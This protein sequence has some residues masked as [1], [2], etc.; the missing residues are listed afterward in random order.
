M[1]PEGPFVRRQRSLSRELQIQDLPAEG[2]VE[3]AAAPVRGAASADRPHW[4]TPDEAE[5]WSSLSDP[6]RRMTWAIGRGLIKVITARYLARNRTSEAMPVDPKEIQ[7]DSVDGLQRRVAPR[8]TW[9]GRWL[10]CQLAL[11]HS[12]HWVAVAISL[13]PECRV[14]IDLVP[15]LLETT[16][17]D[18][19]FSPQ[20]SNWLESSRERGKRRAWLWGMKEAL[21]KSAGNHLAFRP[22]QIELLFNGVDCDSARMG[23]DH[24]PISWHTELSLGDERLIAV[25]TACGST[26]NFAA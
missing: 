5:R 24:I 10:R 4:L 19:A 16:G 17:L 7:I 18:W 26:R 1:R 20:E 12:D 8:V 25:G 11:T 2:P 21:F 13:D 23:Q 3:L 15:G 9:R 22:Q 6:R 14:G